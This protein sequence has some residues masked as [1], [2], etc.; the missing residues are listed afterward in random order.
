MR[1]TGRQL[2]QIIK[3]EVARMMSEEEGV[4]AFKG[5]AA[6]L[7]K[8]QDDAVAAVDK[9]FSGIN[10]DRP[11]QF[12]AV[13]DRLLAGEVFTDANADADVK[14]VVN[15]L[16]DGLSEANGMGI[17]S[18]PTSDFGA[19]LR[20]VQRKLGI[21]A[22]GV[23][24]PQTYLALISGGK[25]KIPSNYARKRKDLVKKI[26]DKIKKKEDFMREMNDLFA[27]IKTMGGPKSVIDDA[28]L[29][30]KSPP[31]APPAVLIFAAPTTDTFGPGLA[32][33]AARSR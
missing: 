14:M 26:A 31:V 9:L 19:N 22:D 33:P 30:F 1:I 24:G 17:I 4:Q 3:E 2:R 32:G 20:T 18:L 21:P 25:V 10:T 15:A 23:F 13:F 5:T 6:D 8:G 16:I 28:V 12:D 7:K 11:A 27:S 29:N